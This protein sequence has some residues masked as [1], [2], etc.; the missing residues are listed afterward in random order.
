[1]SQVGTGFF[2]KEI[3]SFSQLFLSQEKLRQRIQLLNDKIYSYMKKKPIGTWHFG[4]IG[5]SVNLMNQ[6]LKFCKIA[7]FL[8]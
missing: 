2:E 1:M 8:L 6:E 7:Q 4:K 5:V 3:L